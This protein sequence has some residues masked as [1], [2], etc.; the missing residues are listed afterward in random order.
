M[1]QQQCPINCAM[2]EQQRYT[3][4][5]DTGAIDVQIWTTSWQAETIEIVIEIVK[6]RANKGPIQTLLEMPWPPTRTKHA[7]PPPNLIKK[8]PLEVQ[9]LHFHGQ[10]AHT[11]LEPTCA[12]QFG[13]NGFQIASLLQPQ[14]TLT[15]I[16]TEYWDRAGGGGNI[17]YEW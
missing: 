15:L 17:R 5:Y 8:W 6:L 11:N 14:I 3:K 16:K 13:E 10:D 12:Y 1:L 9:H 7:S 2:K 4:I